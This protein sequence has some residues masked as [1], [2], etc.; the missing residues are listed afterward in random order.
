M[1][2]IYLVRLVVDGAKQ[3]GGCKVG[4]DCKQTGSVGSSAVNPYRDVVRILVGDV[5]L[6]HNRKQMAGMKPCHKILRECI[7]WHW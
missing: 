6:D 4:L 1:H 2:Q 3:R 5:S 7:A